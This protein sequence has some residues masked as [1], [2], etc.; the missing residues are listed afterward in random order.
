[1]RAYLLNCRGREHNTDIDG[2]NLNAAARGAH[3]DKRLEQLCR[4]LTEPAQSGEQVQLD[5]SGQVR[6]KLKAP[7]CDSTAHVILS[8]LEFI[9]PLAAQVPRPRLQPP[10]RPVS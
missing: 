4:Y 8:P 5:A 10:G 1:M 9:Q 3:D 2:F 7:W 6:L